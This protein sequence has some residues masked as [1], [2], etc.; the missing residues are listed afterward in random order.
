MN[1]C[2]VY[3]DRLVT[4]TLTGSLLAGITRDTLLSS[5]PT[6]ATGPRRAAS[7]STSGARTAAAAP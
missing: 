1:L 7:P 6:S 3:G 2:F 5:P 4:P